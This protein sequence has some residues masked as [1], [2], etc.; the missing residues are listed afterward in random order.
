MARNMSYTYDFE[1]HKSL[2]QAKCLILWTNFMV[3]GIF[4]TTYTRYNCNSVTS[5]HLNNDCLFI[6]SDSFIGQTFEKSFV[7]DQYYPLKTG[8]KLGNHDFGVISAK[9]EKFTGEIVYFR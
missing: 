9:I 1:E 4:M 8:Y 7:Y 6:V 3:I 2:S 5:T